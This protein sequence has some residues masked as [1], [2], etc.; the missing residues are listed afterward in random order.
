ML[1]LFMVLPV[2]ALY[3]NNYQNAS[4]FLL[5]VA[6]GIYG[7][8]QAIFQ[9]PLGLLSDKLGRRPIIIVGLML[10]I[11]GSVVAALS[12]SAIGVVIGRALQGMGAIASTLMALVT[13]CTSEENR[14][15][16][17]AT[18]GA[19]IGLSFA[20][21]MILGPIISSIVGMAGIFWTTA[22]LGVM[23]I[24]IVFTTVPKALVVRTNRE[25]QTDIRQ[26]GRLIRQP[27]LLRLNLG[28]FFLHLVLM[29]A[30]VIVPSVLVNELGIS[31]GS[32][33]WVYLCL[34]GGGFIIMLPLM[35]TGEKRGRHKQNFIAAIATMA[36]A[37]LLLGYYRN[38]L[39]TPCMLLL[40]FAA[41]NLLEA[42]LPSWLSKVCPVGNRGT[43]MGIYSSFQFM[44]TFIGG[45][46]GGWALASF[47]VSGLFTL[48]GLILLLWVFLALPMQSPKA[49]QTLVLQIGD[50]NPNEF[51]KIISNIV[52]VEDILLV[53]G[54]DLAYVKVDKT[55]V[56]LPSLQPFFNR[57]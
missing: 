18:I 7:F 38:S 6:L 51:A 41:F 25:T 13:D 9:I 55:T 48:I 23:G 54:E 33:W 52:G 40:F 4:P 36:I 37:M 21:A 35:I 2:M 30:F 57:T 24:I 11:L 29:A 43:A 14:T 3:F 16:S 49:L 26:I 31:A 28:I 46:L 47:G 17:M 10:F 32:L 34:L 27:E 39:I 12:D 44:G 5:G 45:L 20:I 1:G 56:D 8:T 42:T 53:E 19:S 50:K 22:I 15:K